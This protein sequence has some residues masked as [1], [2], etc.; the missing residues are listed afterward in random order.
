MNVTSL[1]TK[2][3]TPK[4]RIKIIQQSHTQLN[5]INNVIQE[6][7]IFLYMDKI[8][9]VSLHLKNIL[10]YLKHKLLLRKFSFVFVFVLFGLMGPAICALLEPELKN[11][12]S[13]E[14]HIK[15]TEQLMNIFTRNDSERGEMLSFN[16]QGQMQSIP[17]S[18]EDI[19]EEF[20]PVGGTA[21]DRQN[22]E[23]YHKELLDRF[24]S[25][26]SDGGSKIT[27]E[28]EG[29]IIDFIK[30]RAKILKGV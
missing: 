7:N 8:K 5:K 21:V 18:K 16:E 27:Y 9:P 29:L 22:L 26:G 15:T 10:H 28:E 3:T 11:K 14:Y 2:T 30:E 13:Q 24:S 4:Q 19:T 6:S 12:K 25:P 17:K 1:P 20:P 23:D